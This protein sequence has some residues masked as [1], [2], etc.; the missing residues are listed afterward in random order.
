MIEV[1][2]MLDRI[3]ANKKPIKK[4][5]KKAKKL[6]FLNKLTEKFKK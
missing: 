2:K 1:N 5:K 3:Y 4:S 6:N